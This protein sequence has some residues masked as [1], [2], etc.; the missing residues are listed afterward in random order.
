MNLFGYF[1][2]GP[3]PQ[4]KGGDPKSQNPQWVKARNQRRAER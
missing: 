1:G 4:W 2:L 3:N